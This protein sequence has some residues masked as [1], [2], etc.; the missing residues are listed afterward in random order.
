M[1]EARLPP[2]APRR[3]TWK[4]LLLVV[5]LALNLF[6]LGAGAARL[7]FP[8]PHERFVGST[9][10][11]LVPRRFLM[12]LGHDRRH[13]LLAVLRKY[14]KSYADA[15]LAARQHSVDLADALEKDPY[16]PA[17]VEAAIAAYAKTGN[18]LVGQGQAAAL[19]FIT[20][21]TPDERKMMAE[22]LRQRANLKDRK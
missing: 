11:Q 20:N 17:S 22:R 7:V 6:V 9:Y 5:S 19:D 18:D 13:E 10:A 1:T 3:F 21:L 15:R 14:G 2:P 12:D 8:P 4:R 16:D